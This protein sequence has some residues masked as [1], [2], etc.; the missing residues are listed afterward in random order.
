MSETFWQ[1]QSR[2]GKRVGVFNVPLTYPAQPIHGFM[3]TGMLTPVLGPEMTYPESLHR[4][5]TGGEKEYVLD[6]SWGYYQGQL[7]ALLDALLGMIRARTKALEYLLEQFSLDALIAVF[8]A[9]DRLQHVF[10]RWMDSAHLAYEP[11]EAQKWAGPI[12]Q[13]FAALDDAI[14]TITEYVGPDAVTFVV[15]DHG[16]QRCEK[17]LSL[18]DWLAQN[19]LLTLDRRR[20]RL[21]H[22]LKKAYRTFGA[23]LIRKMGPRRIGNMSGRFR[24]LSNASTIDWRRTKAYC[25]W[26]TQQGVSINLKGR[27]P[28]GTVEPGAEYESLRS[29]IAEGLLSLR[30]PSSGELVLNRV[31][32]REDYYSG[33]FLELAPDLLVTPNKGYAVAPRGVRMFEPTGWY[34]G[35]HSMQGIFIASGQ[36]LRS[37]NHHVVGLRLIDIAPTVLY[38]MGLPVPADM[39]GRVLTELFEPAIVAQNTPHYEAPSGSVSDGR[40]A[41]CDY[42]NDEAKQIT[43]RLRGLGYL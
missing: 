19:G 26:D 33:L 17:Q 9:T 39:D 10:W 5:L 32:R 29:N 6:V 27:E 35:E 36:H 3:V 14:G 22:N 21:I 11:Q 23:P 42:S 40:E 18:D 41:A 15:S 30:D 20:Q 8:T 24:S 13:V 25:S 28:W 43:D 7:G 4:E 16:F 37:R 31:L 38:T 2:H 12:A 1:I 34:S